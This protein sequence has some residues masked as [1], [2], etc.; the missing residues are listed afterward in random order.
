MVTLANIR[1]DIAVK[2]IEIQLYVCMFSV[3]MVLVSM[4]NHRSLVLIQ[5]QAV[6]T[7]TTQLLILPLRMIDE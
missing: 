3:S 7:Q 2:M 1:E 4:P 6:G 5:A